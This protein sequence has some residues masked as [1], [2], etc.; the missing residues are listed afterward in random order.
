MIRPPVTA[1]DRVALREALRP[2]NTF[3]ERG[4]DLARLLHLAT[5]GIS[6]L[7]AR[8]QMVRALARVQPRLE[9]E[10]ISAATLQQQLAD[11][12]ADAELAQQEIS[13]GFPL[14]YAMGVTLLWS[15]LENA[16][17]DLVVELFVRI[18][19]HYTVPDIDKLRVRVGEL[20]SL[21]AEERARLILEQFENSLS[22]PLKAGVGRFE[23]ILVPLGYGGEVAD[24]VKRDI[25]ELQQL[26]NVFVHRQGNID[27]RFKKY[28][29][30]YDAEVGS[31]AAI[32]WSDFVRYAW[33]VDAYGTSVVK[34]VRDVERSLRDQER[35]AEAAGEVPNPPRSRPAPPAA[36]D[37]H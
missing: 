7:L 9:G 16:V 20:L 2:F 18:P 6:G 23:S 30:W 15:D 22:A 35:Q 37:Q 36:D 10:P 29:P 17:R 26:R 25:L 14:L 5:I 1:A 33:A 31:K 4:Q 19:A 34:R 28:C 32:S 27:R 12:T 11:V 21:D 8:P 13:A 24:K 3:I